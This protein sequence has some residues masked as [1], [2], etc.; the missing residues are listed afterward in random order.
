MGLVVYVYVV[1][2]CFGLWFSP[3]IPVEEWLPGIF[4]AHGAYSPGA[5][6]GVQPR[7]VSWCGRVLRHLALSEWVEEKQGGNMELETSLESSSLSYRK[8][9]E[10]DPNFDNSPRSFITGN[11]E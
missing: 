6:T 3:A 10:R 2:S 4:P 5:G 9:Q 8:A 11:V 7:G 1:W